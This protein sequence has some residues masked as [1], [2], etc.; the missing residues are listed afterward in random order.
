MT[1][2][3]EWRRVELKSSR[4]IIILVCEVFQVHLVIGRRSEVFVCVGLYE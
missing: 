1:D 2:K 3:V 4:L